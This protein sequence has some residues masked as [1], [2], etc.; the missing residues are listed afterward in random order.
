[1]RYSTI[2][3]RHDFAAYLAACSLNGRTLGHST[4][5]FRRARG[6]IACLC[7]PAAETSRF[8]PGELAARVQAR[9]TV[10]ASRAQSGARIPLL[11]GLGLLRPASWS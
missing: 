10:E 2:G 7:P 6:S 8:E 3:F 9:G 11:V 5:G 1:M 4:L